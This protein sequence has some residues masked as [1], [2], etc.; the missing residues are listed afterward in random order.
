MAVFSVL[1]YFIFLLVYSNQASLPDVEDTEP[2][3][4]EEPQSPSQGPDKFASGEVEVSSSI[5]TIYNDPIIEVAPG[6]QPH[7]LVQTSSNYGF[8]FMPPILG[9]QLPSSENSES[10]ARDPPRLPS[11]VVCSHVSSVRSFSH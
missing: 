11:F 5:T 1:K 8:G 7:P 10:H 4:P 3:Y 6:S 9:G 2:K